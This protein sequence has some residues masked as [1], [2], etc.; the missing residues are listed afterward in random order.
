MAKVLE[1]RAEFEVVADLD[2]EIL[3]ARVFD[4]A[5][6]A[7]RVQA[8][9]TVR[10][11][12]E[13]E[14]VL[15]QVGSALGLDP[16][17]VRAALFA[18]LKD[19]NRMLRFDDLTAQ[20]LVDSYNLA[21]AQ[22]V[23][24]KSVSL[25]VE[26]RGDT[27]ARYR[28]LFR[29]LKFHRLLTR[30]NGSPAAGYTLQIDGPLSLHTATTKYGLQIALF[31]PSLL[32]ITRYHLEAELRWG[33]KRQPAR[34]VLSESDGLLSHQVE[35]GTY[36]PPEWAAFIERFR[37]IA[38]D[39]DVRDAPEPIPLGSDGFWVPD[40][41]FVHRSSGTEVPVE[42]LGFWKRA[43]LERLLESLP[44]H[45]PPRFLLLVSERLRVDHP[46]AETGAPHDPV[47]RFKEIPNSAEVLAKL[48][49]MLPESKDEQTF[50]LGSD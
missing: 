22:S 50:T 18:D 6:E 31:L 21:L 41:R 26:L 11:R 48:R 14:A 49:S 33:P 39:W 37:Q 36:I 12:F 35:V 30:V 27:P 32:H 7:R 29:S 13:A 5:A 15:Q 25:R 47:V 19:E 3:R 10:T 16:G 20:R 34:F 1:D 23:L 24:L 45:G 17:R 42:W 8:R 46:V 9:S 43:S 40:A 4:T 2:P 28:Q 38:P 44:T